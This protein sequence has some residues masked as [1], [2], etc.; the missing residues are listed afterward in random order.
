MHF[1]HC[2][3]TLLFVMKAHCYMGC[4]SRSCFHVFYFGYQSWSLVS[5]VIPLS[6]CYVLL[7]SCVMFSLVTLVI[8][9]IS[10]WLVLVMWPALFA[11]ST[12][13]VEWWIESPLNWNWIMLLL[14][15][16]MYW[17]CNRLSVS[18]VCSCQ[19]NSG[20][21]NSLFGFWITFVNKTALGFLNSPSVDCSLH[22]LN[23]TQ[24]NCAGAAPPL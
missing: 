23:K 20:H 21:I 2:F 19:V 16:V 18:L 8:C 3:N 12:H 4:V 1:L 6:V 13:H 15:L 10:H 24:F 22:T 11:I 9:P 7:G 17:C 14:S 5:H